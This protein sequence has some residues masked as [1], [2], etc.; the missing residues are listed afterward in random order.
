MTPW[1]ILTLGEAVEIKHGWPFKSEFFIEDTPSKPIVVSIGNFR[2]SGGFRFN[3]TTLKFYDSEYPSEYILSP[4]DILLVM[5]CQTAGGE[6]LGIPGKI[7]SDGNTYLH[8]QR[9][10]KVIFHRPELLD[11]HFAYWLFLS[12]SFNQELVRTASGSKILHTSPGRIQD[13]KTSVPPIAEQRAIA[14][15]LDSLNDKIELNRQMN[16][17]LEEMTRTLF[18]SWFVD[19]DPVHAKAE[20][21]PSEGMDVETAALFPSEFVESEIGM[22]PKGWKSGTISDFASLYREAVNPLRYPEE[23]FYHFSLPAFDDSQMPVL[24]LG[25]AIKSNKGIV[26][27]H[28]VLVSKLNP[29]IPR[30]WLPSIDDNYRRIASTEFLVLEATPGTSREFLYILFSSAGF[31]ERFTGLVTGTSNSHQ[32]VKPDDV[33]ALPVVVPST[34]L[35][36]AYTEIVQPML[37]KVQ[38]NK[39]ENRQLTDSRNM[40]LPKLISGEIRLPEDMVAEFAKGTESA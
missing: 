3:E 32:R 20:G 35:V 6:I 23:K 33:L 36:Q 31:M 15:A 37:E 9:L 4:A 29:H 27:S 30:V 34:Q 11:K 26:P 28:A 22:I 21:R 14:H 40:L 38:T 2:Y 12:P 19:F 7:P 1:T 16:E 13:F 10:G 25:D 17:T 18:R 39:Y 24:E 8:N 5:T